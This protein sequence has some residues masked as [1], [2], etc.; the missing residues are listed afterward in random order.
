MLKNN[1]YRFYLSTQVPREIPCGMLWESMPRDLP[2]ICVSA[3]ICS[4]AIFAQA[5]WALISVPRSSTLVC[6]VH[7]SQRLFLDIVSDLEGDVV[8]CVPYGIVR[9]FMKNNVWVH[10]WKLD[11]AYVQQILRK[12]SVFKM[13]L[14]ITSPGRGSALGAPPEA[15]PG[16]AS[17]LFLKI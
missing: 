13:I 17:R 10:F 7:L 12:G 9:F 15:V 8:T 11:L 5:I 4:A 14:K 16:Y 2:R 6:T 3:C 1:K